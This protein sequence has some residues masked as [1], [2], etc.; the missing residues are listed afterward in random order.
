MAHTINIKN[1]IIEAFRIANIWD[2]AN[3]TIVNNTFVGNTN[4]SL[5][6][7]SP[8]GIGTK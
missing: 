6:G 7:F 3:V 8:G 5:T 1:N 2:A 4:S